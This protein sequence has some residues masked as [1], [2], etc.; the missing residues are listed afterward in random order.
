MQ[1]PEANPTR[2]ARGEGTCI[3]SLRA[4][5]D[6][7]P[8]L[9]RAAISNFL[10]QTNHNSHDLKN[11]RT[12]WCIANCRRQL[13]WHIAGDWRPVEIAPSAPRRM[14][15]RGCRRQTLNEL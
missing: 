4:A 3:S 6:Y 11:N 10:V 12:I 14:I 5:R 15:R 1:E 8:P 9:T 2:D 7:P 13:S